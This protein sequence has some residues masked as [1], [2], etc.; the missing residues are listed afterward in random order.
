MTNTHT[1]RSTNPA[2]PMEKAFF[3]PM[4]AT[5]A[6]TAMSEATATETIIATMAVALPK[7]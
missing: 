1:P 3:L 4:R 2:A 5:T 7:T 6:G